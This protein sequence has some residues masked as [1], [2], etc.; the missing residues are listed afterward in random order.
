MNESKAYTERLVK[1]S[2][3]YSC[4]GLSANSVILEQKF[5]NCLGT[6]DK[7]QQQFQLIE[8]AFIQDL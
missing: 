7:P 6:Y 5:V 2:D 4:S 3:S 1:I 8:D